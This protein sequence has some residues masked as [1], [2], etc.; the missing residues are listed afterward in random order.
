MNYGLTRLPIEYHGSG[1]IH[2]RRKR[3]VPRRTGSRAVLA[4]FG[5][6]G[7]S[8]HGDQQHHDGQT[9]DEGFPGALLYRQVPMVFLGN[10]S[11]AMCFKTYMKARK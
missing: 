2:F 3:N 8:G 4:I 7:K 6:S 1:N 9:Y 10:H 11:C 5:Q